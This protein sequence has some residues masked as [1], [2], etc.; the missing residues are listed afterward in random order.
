MRKIVGT[1]RTN[2]CVGIC[3]SSGLKRFISISGFENINLASPDDH[4]PKLDF[5]FYFEKL[6]DGRSANA[7]IEE[8]ENQ[9]YTVLIAK[10]P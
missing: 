5:I 10:A 4:L 8:T 7:E 6:Y 1:H 9:L 2:N 3:G